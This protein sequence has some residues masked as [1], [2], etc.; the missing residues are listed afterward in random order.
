MSALFVAWFVSTTRLVTPDGQVSPAFSS[1]S[2][3]VRECGE[4][5]FLRVRALCDLCV[6]G[7]SVG[8][9]LRRRDY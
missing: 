4:P 2:Y 9:S 5:Q 6:F 1:V 7:V 3:G 8:G